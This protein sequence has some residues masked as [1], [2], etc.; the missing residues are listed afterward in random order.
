MAKG[1]YRLR[2]P[3]ERANFVRVRYSV[4]A[5]MEITETNYITHG[6]RPPLEDLPWKEAY[7]ERER[8]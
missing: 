5:D 8:S 6:Y 1:I 3:R 7:V 4:G 2:N